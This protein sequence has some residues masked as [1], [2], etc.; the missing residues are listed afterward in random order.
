MKRRTL[1]SV[2][3][4]SGLATSLQ[5]A[6]HAHGQTTTVYYPPV[7]QTTYYS[8]TTVY[9]P[10]YPVYRPT[11]FGVFFGRPVGYYY[12]AYTYPTAYYRVRTR[13]SYYVP[14]VVGYAPV[15]SSAGEC[16]TCSPCATS[17][18]RK[19]VV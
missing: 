17:A 15:T 18:D 5:S 12:P 6:R 16:T 4:L 7:Y 11:L 10:A 3:L 2:V 19:S 9:Y 8:P 14:T 1:W 13:R